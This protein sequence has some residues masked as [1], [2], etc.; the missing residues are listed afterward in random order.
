MTKLSKRDSLLLIVIG[1]LAIVGGIFW[2]YVKPARSDLGTAKQQ[3]QESQQ[4][5]D[6]LQAELTKVTA[7]AKAPAR[8]TIAD[9]LRLA[10]AYPYS[11]EVPITLLQL[12]DLAKKTHVALGDMTP[13]VDTD[14]AGVTGTPFTIDV[15]GKFFDVQDFLYQLHNRVSVS[16]SGRLTVKGRLFA[17]TQADL[18]PETAS[19]TD[20]QTTQQKDAKITAN[21]TVVAF[22]RTPGGGTSAGDAS[23]QASSTG[24]SPS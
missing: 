19:A 4:R 12:E 5:V 20:T 10:K 22:S 13:A 18:S 3:A 2:F 15:T 21:I 1:A 24:G 9:E 14:Y 23:Q 17:I 6:Q 8:H 11:S 16:P 7:A